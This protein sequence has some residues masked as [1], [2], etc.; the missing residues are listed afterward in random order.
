LEERIAQEHGSVSITYTLPD[1]TAPST[2]IGVGPSNPNGQN[3]WYTRAPIVSVSATDPDTD[4]SGVQTRCT[5]DPINSAMSFGAIPSG[6]TY[7]TPGASVGTDGVHA[8]YAASR[9]SVGNTEEQVQQATFKIDT[10]PP[11]IIGAAT[12]LPNSNGWYGANVTVHLTCKDAPSGSGLAAGAC[13]ADQVLS[14]EGS[15]VSS[16]PRTVADLAGNTSAPANIVTL[17]IDKTAPVVSITGVANGATYILGS[18]ATASCSTTDALSGVATP[19]SLH[20][21]G[22]MA[23]GVGTFTATCSG[24]LDEAGNNSSSASATYTVGYGFSGFLAPVDNPSTVNTGKTGR[25]Y[26]VKFQLTNASGGFISS[27]SA[28]NLITAKATACDTFSNDPT[29]ALE[30]DTTGSIGLRYDSTAS[31]FIYTWATPSMAGCYT[32]FV[33]LDSG[34]AYNAYFRLS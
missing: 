14:A 2:T 5:L 7:L 11:T 29:D 27:L 34:Q 19:A 26:P 15:A 10:T 22:G 24:A 32:L 20:V 18:V 6:C 1:T 13:P 33:T 17:K 16:T 9:D 23:N 31:Q 25:A 4:I 3:G 21:T 30:A 12:G 28:V 8:I